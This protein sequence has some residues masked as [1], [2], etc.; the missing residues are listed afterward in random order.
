M[1]ISTFNARC[2]T[3][4]FAQLN[5]FISDHDPDILVIT[6]T[7]LDENVL[8]SEFTPNNYSCFRKDRKLSFYTPGTYVQENR[9]GVMILVKNNLHPTLYQDGEVD[10]EIIWVRINPLPNIS[11][12][13]GGCY[14]PEEDETNILQKI[15]S[16]INSID[17]ANTVLLGDFNFRNIDWEATEGT[18][19]REK[20]FI[21][22]I[23]DNLLVKKGQ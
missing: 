5:D 1:K 3:N 8:N 20:E 17:S 19:D 11:W 6:E 16:S 12:L 4:K 2:L 13:I 23:V 15:N 9:G 22:T 14:R 18:N 7:W 21:D 10:A